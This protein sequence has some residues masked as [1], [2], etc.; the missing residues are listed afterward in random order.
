MPTI[1]NSDEKEEEEESSTTG[2]MRL[3]LSSP[4]E[5]RKKS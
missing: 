5:V 4:A 2:T 1:T 3:A